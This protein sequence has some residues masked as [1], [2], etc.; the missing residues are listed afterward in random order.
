MKIDISCVQQ[1]A[2]LFWVMK[3]TLVFLYVCNK[4]SVSLHILEV[5]MLNNC[6]LRAKAIE[7]VV[8]NRIVLVLVIS[9]LSHIMGIVCVNLHSPNS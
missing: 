5:K 8:I 3:E 4:S 1:N 7:V 2:V 6:F 9:T